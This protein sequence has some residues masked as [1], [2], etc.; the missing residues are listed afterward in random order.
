MG[1]LTLNI[2]LSFAQFERE[3]ISERTRDKIA[4]ARHRGTWAGGRPALGYDLV[5]TPGGSRLVVDEDE[6]VRVRAIFELYLEHARITPVLKGLDRRMWRTKEWTT[7]KGTTIG[8]RPFDQAT[9]YRFLLGNPAYRG[10]ARHRDELYDG[11][12][13]A[14]VDEAVWKRA[15]ALLQ[16]NGRRGGEVVK[17]K[18]G[19]LLKGLVRCVP[20][21]CAMLD[22][23]S[24]K[25]STRY[26]YYVCS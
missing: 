11:E 20:C 4:A 19:A 15:N 22:S 16:R 25:G 12:H 5:A 23:T 1:R 6:A 24:S 8:G 7:R 17:N 13:E 14:I 2:L 26:R 21:G 18:Y 3:I 10:K 9:P